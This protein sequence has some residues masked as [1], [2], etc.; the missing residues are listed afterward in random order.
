MIGSLPARSASFYARGQYAAR[1]EEPAVNS[2]ARKGVVSNP[3]KIASAVGAT[4]IVPALRAFPDSMPQDP[5]PDGWGYYMP[6][7]RTFIGG[8]PSNS[9][10]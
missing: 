8:V 5:H 6:V 7:L 10:H 3:T 1:L 2:H 9:L 4:L